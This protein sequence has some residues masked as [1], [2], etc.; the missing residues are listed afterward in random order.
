MMKKLE[1]ENGHVEMQ[2]ST[3]TDQTPASQPATKSGSSFQEATMKQVKRPIIIAVCLGALLA[4]MG[5]GFGVFKLQAGSDQTDNITADGT[6]VKDLDEA[7]QI[8]VGDVFGSAN[9]EIFKDKAEGVV[10]AGGLEG[11]G[12][13]RLIREGGPSQTVYMTSS[14]VDLDKLVGAKV[15]VWGETN[16]AQK[17]GWFMDVGRVS[18]V[19]LDAALPE[20]AQEEE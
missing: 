16:T 1:L 8:K 9:E 12:T 5:T 4:G 14:V 10:Q 3:A 11:E 6:A 20:W 15:Q 17:A 19:E 7:E 18:V 2:T 13:H